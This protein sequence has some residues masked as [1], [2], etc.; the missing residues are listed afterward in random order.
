MGQGSTLKIFSRLPLA[1]LFSTLNLFLL[2]PQAGAQDNYEIQVYSSEATSKD[3]TIVESTPISRWMDRSRWSMAGPFE[4][5]HAP[6]PGDH[7][8]LDVTNS[9]NH[10]DRE[11]HHWATL[12]VGTQSERRAGVASPGGDARR[13]NGYASLWAREMAAQAAL[14]TAVGSGEPGA[15][16]G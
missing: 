5:R 12:L 10:F 11:V 14:Q 4:S 1:A 2:A 16:A 3:V 13:S 8:G 15:G 6:N 9:A 7:A